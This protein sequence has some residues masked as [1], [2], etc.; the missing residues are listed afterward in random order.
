[1]SRVGGS[2]MQIL[3]LGKPLVIEVLTMVAK[4][5]FPRKSSYLLPSFICNANI[6]MKEVLKAGGY[7]LVISVVEVG[8]SLKRFANRC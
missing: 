2:A 8:N 4:L 1:M 6:V 7:Y 5:Y 3:N